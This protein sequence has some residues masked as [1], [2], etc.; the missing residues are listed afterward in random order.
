MLRLELS[1]RPTII[2]FFFPSPFPSLLDL[3]LWELGLTLEVA[4][5]LI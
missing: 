5:R 3:P 1:L 2:S 4:I